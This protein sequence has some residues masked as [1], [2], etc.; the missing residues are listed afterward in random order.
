[1]ASPLIFNCQDVAST[2]QLNH[3][4]AMQITRVVPIIDIMIMHVTLALGV[5][6]FFPCRSQLPLSG[7]IKMFFVVK[8]QS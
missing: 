6:V 5:I 3:A 7:P 2:C 1:M 4:I 8:I